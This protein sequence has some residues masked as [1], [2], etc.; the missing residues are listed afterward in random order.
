MQTALHFES[1]HSSLL[2]VQDILSF[3]FAHIDFLVLY[4]ITQ[5]LD[6][7]QAC[8]QLRTHDGVARYENPVLV[9]RCVGQS[10]LLITR[11]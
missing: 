1:N 3:E 9:I 10:H 11:N 7:G 4:L 2:F 8:L 6:D 5:L